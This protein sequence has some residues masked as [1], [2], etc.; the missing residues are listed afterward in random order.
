[1][2]LFHYPIMLLLLADEGCMDFG[3]PVAQTIGKMSYIIIRD[4]VKILNITEFLIGP[5]F[6]CKVAPNY[7]DKMP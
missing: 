6:T 2:G 4:S 5:S 3:H 7:K 1:M